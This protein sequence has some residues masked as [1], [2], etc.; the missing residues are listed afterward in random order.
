MPDP[1]LPIATESTLLLVLNKLQEIALLLA[2]MNTLIDRTNFNLSRGRQGFT[3]P[4]ES[5]PGP[6]NW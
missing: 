5:Y 2:A 6:G 4:H 1:G 3:S